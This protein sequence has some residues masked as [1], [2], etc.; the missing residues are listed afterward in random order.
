MGEP[1]GLDDVVVSSYTTSE[2]QV[3]L[4]T[5]TGFDGL[6]SVPV[7]ELRAAWDSALEQLLDG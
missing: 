4:C 7:S 5:T 6:A 2:A 1:D 3:L